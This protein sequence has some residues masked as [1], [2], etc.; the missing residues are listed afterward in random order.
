MERINHCQND[1]E[2]KVYFEKKMTYFV[3]LLGFPD[4]KEHVISY[5][6]LGS[7]NICNS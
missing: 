3:H 7:K 4:N 1:K 5:I 6:K 2:S